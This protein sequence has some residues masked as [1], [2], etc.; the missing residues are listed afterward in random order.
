[1]LKFTNI[2]FYYS[3][4]FLNHLLYGTGYNGMRVYYRK[5]WYRHFDLNLTQLVGANYIKL[6]IAVRDNTLMCNVCSPPGD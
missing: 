3:C 6:Q 1:M 2:W 5:W 4:G